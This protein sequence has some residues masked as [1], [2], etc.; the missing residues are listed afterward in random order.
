ML[1][2]NLCEFDPVA[3]AALRLI[4]RRIGTVN[5]FVDGVVLAQRGHTEAASHATHSGKSCVIDH[6]THLLGEEQCMFKVG[7]WGED[8]ELLSAPTRQ[9]I[10][11]AHASGDGARSFDQYLIANQVPVGV[12][13]VLEAVDVVHDQCQRRLIAFAACDLGR[14]QRIEFLAVVQTRQRIAVGLL[15][16]RQRERFEFALLLEHSVRGMFELARCICQLLFQ[17]GIGSTARSAAQIL[18]PQVDD[19]VLQSI[20]R[21]VLPAI[22]SIQSCAPD[23]SFHIGSLGRTLCPGG[24]GGNTTFAVGRFDGHYEFTTITR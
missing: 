21:F 4:E 23:C 16:Q 20:H 2:K 7:M 6:G 19:I 10:R 9:G 22:L 13:D 18:R 5:E 14:A 12:I 8:H 11:F 17:P 3:A 1:H 15:L 24:R